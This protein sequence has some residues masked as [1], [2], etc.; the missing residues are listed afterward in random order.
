[1]N[2][3]VVDGDVSYPPTSGKRLRTLHLM[4]PLAKRHRLT[5]IARGQGNPQEDR[6]AAEF[7]GEHGIQAHIVDDPLPRKKGPAFY[8]RLALNLLSRLPYSV[9]SHRSDR[10]LQAVQRHAAANPVDLWQVEW[11]GYLY[12]VAGLK[13]P[14]VLQAHNVDSLI[15]QRYHETEQSAL[16]RWYVGAQWRKFER[17]EQAAFAS[18]ARVIAVSP[19]DAALAREKFGVE[20]IDVVDNGVD[21]A[22]FAA[23]RP[24]EHSRSILYLGALD[25]RPNIDALHLLL[26]AI[27]PAV[28]ALE[29]AA[30]LVIVGRRPSAALRQKIAAVPGAELHADVPDVRP[31]LATSLVMAVP[32]RIGGGSRLK[33]LESLAAGLPVVSTRVGAEGLALRPELDYTLADTPEQ[34]ASALL[35]CLRRPA[36]AMAQADHGRETVRGRYDWQTLADRLGRVWEKAASEGTR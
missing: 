7:L 27:F 25:W 33:I 3:V 6:Q 2:V 1:M 17:F 15:W 9:T 36:K 8:G 22:H 24:E 21:V 32:L 29:P 34:M 31:F 12:T 18:V 11:T 14:V 26:D 4:L 16:K 19:E 20:R 5:Y 30:R 13:A 28:H 23:V 10:M 35:D